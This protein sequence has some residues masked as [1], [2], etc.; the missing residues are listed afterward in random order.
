MEDSFIHVESLD[1]RSRPNEWTITPHS[2]AELAHIF[3]LSGGG[4]MI[5]ADAQRL[6]CR[7][8]CLLLM[9]VGVVHGFDWDE[10]TVGFVITVSIRRLLDLR[11]LSRDAAALLAQPAVIPLGAEDA[12]RIDRHIGDLLQE[13][14]WAR[15]GHEAAVQSALLAVLVIA[16]RQQNTGTALAV[17]EG[18]YRSVVARLRERIE[19]R[20]RLRESVSSYARAL[21]TSETALRLAARRVAGMSPGAMLNHRALLEGKRSLIFSD[22]TI[23]EIAY[24]LGFEDAAYFSRFFKEHVGQSPR[25]YRAAQRQGAFQDTEQPF[26]PQV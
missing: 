2:H 21:G 10:Q 7:A 15:V 4:G 11:N 5:N 16:L 3:Y 20:F 26:R 1:D 13:L 9:P 18:R 25:A 8:P 17:D 14:G 22:L 23:S 19:H 12:S 6:R 24:S